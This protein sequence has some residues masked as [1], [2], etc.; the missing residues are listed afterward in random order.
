MNEDLII[1]STKQWWINWHISHY[2]IWFGIQSQRRRAVEMSHEYALKEMQLISLFHHF[3]FRMS[4]EMS[5]KALFSC[6]VRLCTFPKIDPWSLFYLL[7][8]QKSFNFY[9]DECLNNIAKWK[10][11]DG[12]KFYGRMTFVYAPFVVI[13]SRTYI[14]CR[15]LS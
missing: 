8:I 1:I 13:S 11:I 5:R 10:L 15:L 6:S 7:Y 3:R 14:V 2:L 4:N 9:D 12:N